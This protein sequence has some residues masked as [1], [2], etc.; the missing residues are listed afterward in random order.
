MKYW[1]LDK[2]FNK[3]SRL[4]QIQYLAVEKS[5][6][7]LNKSQAVERFGVPPALMVIGNDLRER[8]PELLGYEDTL[9]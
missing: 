3:C 9:S 2:I 8:F 4:C 1:L 5:F 6:L 7:I